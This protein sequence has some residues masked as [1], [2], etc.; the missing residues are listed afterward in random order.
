MTDSTITLYSD[1]AW[2]NHPLLKMGT[3][4]SLKRSMDWLFF[5]S[6]MWNHVDA[7]SNIMKSLTVDDYERQGEMD[8]RLIPVRMVRIP[9][10]N[11]TVWMEHMLR[12]AHFD[13]ISSSP[14]TLLE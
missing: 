6:L 11:E 10:W 2:C 9:R 7:H 3:H 5:I 4:P 1:I 8:G 12:S 14:F 13:F